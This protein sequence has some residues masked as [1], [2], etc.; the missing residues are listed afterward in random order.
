[1][2]IDRRTFLAAGGAA[3]MSAPAMAQH[4]TPQELPE[5]FLPRRIRLRAEFPAGEIH[6]I[7]GDFALYW[8]EEDRYAI[9]YAVGI[10]RGDLYE[11]G[12][13]WIRAKKEWPGWKPTPEM[14]ER[15][16]ELYKDFEE[17]EKW[18]NGQPGGPGNPLGARALYLFDEVG[19]D[20]YLRIHGTNRPRTIGT[21]VSNGCARLINSHIAHL[22]ELV[23]LGTKVVLYPKGWNARVG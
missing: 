17:G 10:G 15:E 23:P 1:M 18:E 22:Y 2:T 4:A 16:P 7:P 21:A 5:E 9:R 8:T 3:A 20:T 12:T 19:R 14:M 6:L 13:F 11:A